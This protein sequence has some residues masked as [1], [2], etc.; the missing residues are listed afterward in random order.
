VPRQLPVAALKVRRNHPITSQTTVTERDSILQQQPQHID[1]ER[2][3]SDGTEWHDFRSK[4]AQTRSV[5]ADRA[6]A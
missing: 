5:K 4:F 3:L 2:F 1:L 6:D